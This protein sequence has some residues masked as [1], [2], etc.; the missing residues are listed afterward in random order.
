MNKA[1]Q[2]RKGY[3]SYTRN[4]Q[5]CNT[6]NSCPEMTSEK[7]CSASALAQISALERIHTWNPPPRIDG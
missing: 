7:R 5:F 2:N 3:L 4:L 1:E 6:G